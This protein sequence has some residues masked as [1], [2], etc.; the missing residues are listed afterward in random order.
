MWK[1]QLAKQVH[2][3]PKNLHNP[4]H[5]EDVSAKMVKKFLRAKIIHKVL[6]DP[7]RI[8]AQREFIMNLCVCGVGGCGGG[9]GVGGVSM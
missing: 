7:Q 8:R 5:C 2:N 4:K 3:L 1:I 9:G 6:K